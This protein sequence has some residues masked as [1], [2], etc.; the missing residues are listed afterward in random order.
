MK[1]IHAADLHLGSKIEAKFI[2]ISEERKLAVRDS[3]RR[4]VDYAKNNQI[5][6]I[7]L[8]GDVFDDDKPFKKDKDF[9]YG[10]IEK[11]PD[12][13]F[14]YLRGN[15]DEAE[16]SLTLHAN[17][18][19]FTNTW[20]SYDL[21]ENVTVSGLELD[22]SNYSTFYSS[23]SL[24]LSKINI[25]MLHGQESG[26]IAKESIKISELKEKYIDYLA[27]G[28]IHKFKEGKIDERGI[29]VYP[30]CL[31]GR[32]FDEIGEKGFVEITIEDGKVSSKFI[33]F[34]SKDILEVEVDITGAKS[35][36]DIVSL[37]D[38]NVCFNKKDI[39]RIT[40]IGDVDYELEFN[41]EDIATALKE[42]A[43]FINVK[44]KTL[45]LIDPNE[46]INDLSLKGEFVRLVY[47]DDSLDEISKRKI[48]S[49]GLKVLEGREAVIE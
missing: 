16:N 2:S 38:E 20:T 39:Y 12:I 14:Y 19:E 29:Y 5:S 37:I 30:G 35:Q 13:T 45:P 24:D 41:E 17:L 9:F 40:L 48:I 8:S 21:G 1:L 47:S 49:L 6:S 25:V 7:L 18:K 43:Y 44:N 32:G 46:F 22:E 26:S 28:H 31:E 23:L 15:H 4:L 42:K 10:V 3:F 11:N 36:Q 34:S 33:H 27:L